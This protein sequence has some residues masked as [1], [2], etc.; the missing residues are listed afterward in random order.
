MVI[1]AAKEGSRTR[2]LGEY[3]FGPRRAEEHTNQRIVAA[4]SGAW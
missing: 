2:G 4:W 3:L 1:T